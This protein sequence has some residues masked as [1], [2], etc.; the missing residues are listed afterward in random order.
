MNG[1]S[2]KFKSVGFFLAELGIYTGFV[3]GYFFLVLHL[4]GDWIKHIFDENKIYYA[5]VALA[6]ILVQGVLLQ[7]LTSALFGL[8][9]RKIR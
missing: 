7:L 1:F 8:I 5:I 4:M 3:V 2:R 6:L 9:R